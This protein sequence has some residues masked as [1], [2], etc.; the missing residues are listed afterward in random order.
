MRRRP[1]SG[2]M[3]LALSLALAACGGSEDG[4]T[5]PDDGGPPEDTR[6]VKASPSFADD[7]MEI[8]E[9]RGCAQI[10]CHGNGSTAG[11]LSLD[12]TATAYDQLVNVVSGCQG[13][14]RVVPGDPDDSYLVMKVEGT[15]TCGA[16]MPLGDQP[17][18]SIDQKNI[19]NWVLQN[20]LNN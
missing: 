12:G 13:L 3:V 5:A 10:G 6:V 4:P 7:I 2:P 16:R 18:D 1:G 8:V 17:L 15:H 14:I 11:A 20:A 9:R 19:R